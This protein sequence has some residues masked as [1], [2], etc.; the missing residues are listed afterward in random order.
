MLPRVNLV[1]ADS[2][3]FLLF[4]TDDAV[5]RT[6]YSTGS[7][8]SPLLTISNLFYKGEDAPLILDVGANLGSYAIPVAKE[9]AAAGGQ[10][11][12]YVPPG[13]V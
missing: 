5:S 1:R 8:A 2:A 4:S 11:Y 3:D 10:V 6:I 13:G 7:W 12:C 9:I